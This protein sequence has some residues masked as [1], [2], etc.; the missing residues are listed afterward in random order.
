MKK[1][2]LFITMILIC[3]FAKA[4]MLC[5]S[6]ELKSLDQINFSEI[7]YTKCDTTINGVR[8][9]HQAS[10]SK[11]K[12]KIFGH[13]DKR[14]RRQGEWVVYDQEGFL[15]ATGKF[16]NNKKTG[17]WQYNGCCRTLYKSDKIKSRVCVTFS[18]N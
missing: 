18:Y 14:K 5:D 1:H 2:F 9:S 4:Q 13:I 16:K 3:C 17:W 10:C 6:A 12:M 8:Y 7:I 11:N 15:F